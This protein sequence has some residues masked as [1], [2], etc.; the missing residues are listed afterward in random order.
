V[1]VSFWL[2]CMLPSYFMRKT[3]SAWR[4]LA[5]TFVAQTGRA[6]FPCSTKQECF[7]KTTREGYCGSAFCLFVADWRE[8]EIGLLLLVASVP[9]GELH[10]R[11][12]LL[13]YNDLPQ[14]HT[15]HYPDALAHHLFMPSVIKHSRSYL[16]TLFVLTFFYSTVL[17]AERTTP[18]ATGACLAC[19]YPAWRD[20]FTVTQDMASFCF[21]LILSRNRTGGCD[22]IADRA[23]TRQRS[24]RRY[25]RVTGSGRRTAGGACRAPSPAHSLPLPLCPACWRTGRGLQR[26]S[27]LL[28]CAW[29][30]RGILTLR[31]FRL[32]RA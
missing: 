10:V 22:V 24:D 4:R 30:W 13:H 5:V 26:R 31:T 7:S 6:M 20:H 11:P 1:D 29:R 9:L 17:V 21:F 2:A 15:Q 27:A 23:L 16:S 8:A 32:R 19:L 3:V 12:A 18:V 14:Q 28:S 25:S